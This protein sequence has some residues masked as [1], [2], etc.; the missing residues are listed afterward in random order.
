MRV[1]FNAIILQILCTAYVF[2]RGWEVLPRIKAIRIP[3]A[4]FFAAELIIYFI[5]FFAYRSLNPAILYFVAWTGT[6]WMIFI[7]YTIVLLLAYD[8]I[9]YIANKKKIKPVFIFLNSLKVRRTYYSMVILLVVG[10]MLYGSYR[11]HHPVVTEL[12]LTVKKDSPKLKSIRIVMVSDIHAGFLIKKE[13]LKGYVDRIMEQ[14]PD[15]ILLVGDI[16]DYDLRSLVIEHMDEEFQQLKAPYGVFASTGNHEYI[17]LDERD[18]GETKIK[19]L[20][21]KAGL[22]VLRD[23]VAMIDSSLYIIGREDDKSKNRKPLVQIMDGLDKTKPA[24]V[25]NHEPHKLAEESDAGA[26][27]ALYGHTHNGQFFPNNLAIKMLYE[28][29]YGYK[30]K[31]NTHMYVSSGLGLA[32]PQFRIGTISEIV[33]LNVNFEK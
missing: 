33:V 1:F 17:Y 4:T 25:M 11:F 18:N 21:E 22:T 19:W 9:R 31:D 30:Q 5:G 26:D 7:L 27:I 14:N 16:I 8:I 24:I 3:Y 12:N 6:A 10:V 13:I 28:M 20:S 32:G 15:M 29:G 2:Y 23:S